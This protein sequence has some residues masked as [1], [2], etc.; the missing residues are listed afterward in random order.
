MVENF[1][2]AH[3][4]AYVRKNL[5]EPRGLTVTEA[6]KLIGLSRQSVSNFLN[7]KVSA[8]SNMAAR[9]ERTFGISS[10]K[11]LEMQTKYDAQKEKKKTVNSAQNASPYVV[12]LMKFKANDIQNFF[13]DDLPARSLLAV[14]LR[15]LIHSTGYDL[16]KVDFP[17]NDDAERP[18]WDGLVEAGSGTPWIPSGSS[19]W[20]FGVNGKVKS[21]AEGDFANRVNSH[22]HDDAEKSNITFVFV[23]PRRWPG[24]NAWVEEKKKKK[25]WKDVRAY[26]ASDLE[27]WLE[28]SSIAQFWFAEQIGRSYDGVKTLDSCWHDWADVTTPVLHPLLFASAI[29][30]GE[31]K[32]KSFLENDDANAL[33]ISADSPEEAE[34][35]LYQ[36]LNNSKFERFRDKVLVFDKEGVLPKLAQGRADFIALI[37]KREVAEELGAYYKSLKTIVFYPRNV[38]NVKF[39][40]VLQ[41]LTKE[42]FDNALEAM[43]MSHDDIE[44]MT[45]ASGRSLTILRRLLANRDVIRK[46]AWA[47]K[48]EL[49]KG[50]FP[51]LLVGSWDIRNES[52]QT[53]LS[54]LAGVSWELLEDRIHELLEFEDSP[55]WT[56]GGKQGV[57]SKIDALFSVAEK[58]SQNDLDRFFEV[59]RMVLGEDG[60]SLELPGKDRLAVRYGRKR[61]FSEVLRTSISE[62]MVILAIHGQTLF[63]KRLGIDVESEIAKIVRELLTPLTIQKLQTRRS[64]LPLYAEADPSV[65]LRI[66]EEDLRKEK[67][68][69]MKLM[70]PADPPP[71]GLCPR[72][73]LIRALECLA[74]N[75]DTFIRVVDILGQMSEIKIRDNW[76]SK[77]I[78]LLDSILRAWMP[79]TAAD[80]ERRLVAVQRLLKNHPMVGWKICIE[81]I[82]D[83]GR[84]SGAYNYKP[85]WRRD[86]HGFGEPFQTWEPIHA[87]AEEMVK[88]ALN[89]SSYTVEMLCD[90]VSRVHLIAP[91]QQEQVWEIV[92]KWRA[93]GTTKE[94]IETIREKIR[95]TFLSRWARKK[96][97]EED[98]ANLL[99]K[100]REIYF[101]LQPKGIVN[102]YEYLF[103]QGWVDE[104][105]GEFLEDEKD[106]K[107]RE[108]RIEERRREALIKIVRESGIA[109][110][111]ALSD[112]AQYQR[113]IGYLLVSGILADEQIEDLILQCL[114]P[115]ENET[116]RKEI[117]SEVLRALGDERRKALYERLQGKVP[118]EKA[119]RLLFL[120]PYQA[121]TWKLVD[122]LLVEEQDWYWSE[123]K[124][125]CSYDSAEE[126]N[127]SVRRLLKAG[128]PRAAFTSMEYKL[129]EIE[130]SLLVQMLSAMAKKSQDKAGE[131]QLHGAEIGRAFDLVNR[132]SDLTLAEKA[133]LE[134]AYLDV[135]APIFRWEKWQRIPNLE[136]LIEEHPE[137][138][139]QAVVWACGRDDGGVDPDEFQ[140][141]EGQEHWKEK[142]CRLLEA[143]GH[144]PGQDKTTVSEQ[145]K[146]L[147][148]W[149]TA[150]RRSCAE[151]GRID[152]ADQYLGKLFSHALPG[153]DGVWPN[154]AVRDVMEDLQSEYISHGAYIG[155]RNARGPHWRKEGGDQERELANKYRAWADALQ[156]SYPFVAS[157]L[158]M[159]MA[160]TYECEAEERDTEANIRRRLRH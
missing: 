66:V 152:L 79:Q 126:N 36:T 125:Q 143:L 121:S 141:P 140:V 130:P 153:K 160:K 48:R 46:P 139:V 116:K 25:L 150:V 65:F 85:K 157:T 94:E 75:P 35:F 88:L 41:P 1:L 33:K 61:E 21:K 42:T 91:L 110:V 137:L 135:L 155:L 151:L 144:V 7:G 60:S 148:E 74:W 54:L 99:Q 90:L 82:R 149:V 97:N 147:G 27:Q 76:G 62:S 77:P 146:M 73:G 14:F 53:I 16:Q 81:Q 63:W 29:D 52:D 57:I 38:T 43:K 114:R 55:I 98:H 109:G 59:A 10:T 28:Q 72:T 105:L 80:H 34:A 15:I 158:L 111:L 96:F 128:R 84:C 100:A 122:Q 101:E 3:P 58:V 86:G 112:K 20:E 45:H 103:R 129:E 23:T 132:T 67:S 133:G 113:P 37:A 142:A 44:K 51:L 17:G 68:E 124:P 106:Y 89:R 56:F 18:G 117:I 107:A 50:L 5:L 69:V 24:K 83:Y 6:A 136:R 30:A 64:E 119:L 4:G 87:F 31:G 11:I 104:V 159:S 102:K 39:D 154:E 123:V 26:D 138:Y 145:R 40:V 2:P 108:K 71:Q 95:L 131:Y 134:L 115:S 92:G 127:E 32:I 19:R 8:T 118:R 49:A 93:A 12:P 13:K 156:F 9:L 120:S 78:E 47:K 70:K 22:A